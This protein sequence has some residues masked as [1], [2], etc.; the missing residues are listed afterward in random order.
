MNIKVIIY[1]HVRIAIIVSLSEDNLSKI[2]TQIAN[3]VNQQRPIKIRFI[4]K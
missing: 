4:L 1:P 3:E 2:T